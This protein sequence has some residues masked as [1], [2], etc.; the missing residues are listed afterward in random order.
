[1]LFPRSDYAKALADQLLSPSG[2]HTSVR[3]GV[4]LSNIRRVGKSTFL[5]NELVPELRQRGA[6]VIYVDL[7]AD[8][9]RAPLDLVLE[10]VRKELRALQTPGADMLKRLKGM[11]LGAAGLSLSF[12]LDTLGRQGGATLAQAMR[13]LVQKAWTDVVLIVDEVQQAAGAAGNAL[14]AAL[15]ATRDE[16]NGDPQAPGHFLFVG[17]GSHRSLMNDMA[18]KP[19]HPFKGAVTATFEPLPQAYVQWKLNQLAADGVRLPSPEAAWRGFQTL[20]HRPEE[21]ERAL[22]Q[23]QAA[24]QGSDAEFDLICATLASTAADLEFA[25]AGEIGGELGELVFTRI[26][27]GPED[28]TRELYGQ[29]ALADYAAALDMAVEVK[30]V[31]NAVDALV[32][33]NLIARIGHGRFIIS[34]PY[35]RSIWRQRKAITQALRA[36]QPMPV[37]RGGT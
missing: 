21:L 20:G 1:M 28:G 37:Q 26:A 5:R 18:T 27:N 11:G 7:W 29:A 14:M 15:K 25:R 9:N 10:A 24:P 6:I 31:Q 23:F 22:G 12:Q 32:A 30:Q 19:S 16:V 35:V 4:F 13:E 8:V 34:D 2:L 33:A 17:T 36:G 3:S